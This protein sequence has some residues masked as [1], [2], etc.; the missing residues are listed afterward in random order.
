MAAFELSWLTWLFGIDYDVLGASVDK[1]SEISIETKI[2]D[3]Y[4]FIIRHT[5]KNIVGNTT[6]DVFSHKP[7]RV[8][9]I[10][11]TD[12]NVE[13]DWI[14]NKVDLF[15]SDGTL[16]STY[17]EEDTSV[18]EGYTQFSTEKMYV[19]EIKN[20]IS[21]V[22]NPQIAKCKID[23][24]FKVLSCVKKIERLSGR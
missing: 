22:N 12:G 6:I 8:L 23:D 7:Y 2:D 9:R 1:L 21:S 20:F 16:V 5:K 10:A 18:E 17:S 3:F 11:G 24:D 14:K 13:F 4:S 19:E 15:N